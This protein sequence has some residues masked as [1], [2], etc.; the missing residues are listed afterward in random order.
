MGAGVNGAPAQRA[1]GR[2][3]VQLVLRLPRRFYGRIRWARSGDPRG[4]WSARTCVEI[5]AV[6]RLRRSL[7]FHHG[8]IDRGVPQLGDTSLTPR[9]RK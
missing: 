9:V 5:E 8:R 2:D 1:V 6:S 7:F 4:L 3:A